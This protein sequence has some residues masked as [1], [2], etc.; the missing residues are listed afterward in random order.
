MI[1]CVFVQT[2]LHANQIDSVI[3]KSFDMEKIGNA[4]VHQDTIVGDWDP[5]LL[6]AVSQ[7]YAMKFPPGLHPLDLPYTIRQVHLPGECTIQGQLTTGVWHVLPTTPIPKET[8]VEGYGTLSARFPD[9]H[10]AFNGFMFEALL[11]VNP[12]D[13]EVEV[14]FE[15]VFAYRATA[16]AGHGYHGYHGIAVGYLPGEETKNNDAANEL[17]QAGESLG[18]HPWGGGFGLQNEVNV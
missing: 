14:I 2:N 12:G 9:L 7:S 3:T 11:L 4:Q 17:R 8:H 15:L 13:H 5:F 1:I 18:I 10:T 16:T 6:G